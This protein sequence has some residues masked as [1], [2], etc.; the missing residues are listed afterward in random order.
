MIKKIL[1][2]LLIRLLDSTACVDYKQIDKK[3]LEDWA[4][5]SFHDKGWRSYF[6]SEDMKILKELSFG[7]DRDQYMI[8]IGKRLQLL[9]MFD[10]MRKSFEL[11]KSESERKKSLAEKEIKKNG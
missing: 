4:F 7:K 3:A 10:E 9:Y 11:K 6:A 2:G 8:L 1:I 5:R